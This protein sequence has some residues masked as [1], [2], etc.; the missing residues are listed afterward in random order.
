VP[1]RVS[2]KETRRFARRRKDVKRQ[3]T[4]RLWPDG[5]YSRRRLEGFCKNKN[6]RM[7]LEED[8]ES[9]ARRRLG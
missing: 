7:G 1:E 4:R 2:K 6:K 5:D 3:G 8:L 9:V